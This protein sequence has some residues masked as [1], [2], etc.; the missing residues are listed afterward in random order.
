MNVTIRAPF[1]STVCALVSHGLGIAIVDEFTLAADQWPQLRA[2]DIAEPTAFETSFVHRKDVSLSSAAARLSP[3]CALRWKQSPDCAI[4]EKNNIMLSLG[5]VL[6]IDLTR[7]GQQ[8][9]K[10]HWLRSPIQPGRFWPEGGS[11]PCFAQDS[12]RR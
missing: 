2:L 12:L 7:C 10:C 3:L 8:G 6:V 11:L 5:H 9:R 1:G 4:L